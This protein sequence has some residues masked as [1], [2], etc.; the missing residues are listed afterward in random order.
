MDKKTFNHYSVYKKNCITPLSEWITKIHSTYQDLL[1][2]K[3][4]TFNELER[5]QRGKPDH[6]PIYGF[7]WI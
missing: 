2:M 3:F 1:T 4:K 5:Y 6:R 7:T